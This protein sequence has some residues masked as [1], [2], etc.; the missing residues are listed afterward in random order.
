MKI[1][2][3]SSNPFFQTGMARARG[4]QKDVPLQALSSFAIGYSAV[5][6]ERPR[7]WTR[8]S[9][10]WERRVAWPLYHRASAR[11]AACIC[12]VIQLKTDAQNILLLEMAATSPPPLSRER[13]YEDSYGL[14]NWSESRQL[15]RSV[16]KAV[17]VEWKHSLFITGQSFIQPT[18]QQTHAALPRHNTQ[19][20]VCLTNDLKYQIT[21]RQNSV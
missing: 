17:A 12:T 5:K 14:N 15:S 7:Y 20:G 19:G 1:L 21:L 8:E 6:L 3:T 10:K 2:S 9:K 11:P 18:R 16:C 13:A 4:A